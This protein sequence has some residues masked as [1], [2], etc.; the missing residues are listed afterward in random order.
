MIL[1]VTFTISS[2]IEVYIFNNKAY[3][4]KVEIDIQFC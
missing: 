3:L 1:H 4:D 2:Y